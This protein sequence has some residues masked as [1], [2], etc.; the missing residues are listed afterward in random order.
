MK[1]IIAFILNF[2]MVLLGIE[3]QDNNAVRLQKK[4]DKNF[5]PF[6]PI[7]RRAEAFLLAHASLFLI[8]FITI[9]F[10][11]LTALLYAIIGVSAVDSGTYYNHLGDV[12]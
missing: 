1:R 5:S 12:I 2:F 9:L 6:D 4:E 10:V 8:I 11:L 7:L 3:K